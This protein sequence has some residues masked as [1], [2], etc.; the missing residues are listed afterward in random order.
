ME[1]ALFDLGYK[2]RDLA[3]AIGKPH[4]NDFLFEVLSRIDWMIDNGKFLAGLHMISGPC[5][6]GRPKQKG[7]GFGS[8][9]NVPDSV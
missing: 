3:D 9:A 1:S 5:L 2:L 7:D 6:K 8:V 4:I